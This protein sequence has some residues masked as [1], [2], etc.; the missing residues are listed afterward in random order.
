VTGDVSITEQNFITG[1]YWLRWSLDFGSGINTEVRA[2]ARLFLQIVWNLNYLLGM[3]L[4]G[5]TVIRNFIKI[6]PAVPRLKYADSRTVRQTD[7]LDA[8]YM[9]AEWT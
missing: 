2:S 8:I 3:A 6:H 1:Y 9:S 4:S 7:R 5:M